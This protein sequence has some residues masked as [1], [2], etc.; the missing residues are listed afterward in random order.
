[1]WE[2]GGIAPLFL[3]SVLDGGV[4]LTS[5]PCPFTSWNIAPRYP[6]VR[7]GASQSRCG[8]RGEEKHLFSPAGTRTPT[9]HPVTV[10]TTIPGIGGIAPLLLTL[11]LDAGEWAVSRSGRFITGETG[12]DNKYVGGR[13][14][15]ELGWTLW[16]TVESLVSVEKRTR[17]PRSCRMCFCRNLLKTCERCNT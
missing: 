16:R 15:P 6:L 4:W 10:A 3:S 17:T 11:T 14:G 13:E 2:S 12:V 9:V 8:R 1:V 7:L 5:R